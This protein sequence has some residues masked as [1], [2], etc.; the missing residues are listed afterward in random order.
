M[1][2]LITDH[3]SVVQFTA[4]TEAAEHFFNRLPGGRRYG[5]APESYQRIGTNS[6]AADYRVAESIIA[7]LK[8]EGYTVAH[9][10]I[11]MNTEVLD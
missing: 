4:E 9:D 6:F 7:I 10:S 8:H 11:Y 1:D 2:V 3:G 5:L